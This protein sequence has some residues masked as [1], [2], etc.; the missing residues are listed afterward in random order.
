MTTKR[1]IRNKILTIVVGT[2]ILLT[3]LVLALGTV[4]FVDANIPPLI[5]VIK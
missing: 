2:T 3:S 4:E 1:K 5:H